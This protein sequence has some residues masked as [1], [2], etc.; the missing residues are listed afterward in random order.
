MGLFRKKV[1][2]ICG[3]KLVFL[4]ITPVEGGAICRRCAETAAP[5]AR[6]YYIREHGHEPEAGV[7][8]LSRLKVSEISRIIA[9][10]REEKEMGISETPSMGSTGAVVIGVHAGTEKPKHKAARIKVAHGVLR[11]G[12]TLIC[13]AGEVR[14]VRMEQDGK[15]VSEVSEG[16]EALLFLEGDGIGGIRTGAVLLKK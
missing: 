8:P 10:V 2:P 1:C 4:E 7:D 5:K 16:G 12:D 3:A 13:E 9:H 6:S 11:I 14:I 15:P